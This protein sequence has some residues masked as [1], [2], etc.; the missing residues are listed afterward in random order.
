[1]YFPRIFAEEHTQKRSSS[2][3]EGTFFRIFF[4]GFPKIFVHIQDQNRHF[5]VQGPEVPCLMYSGPLM[6]VGN[7]C[8]KQCPSYH[9]IP[10]NTC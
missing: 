5:L 7:H 1:M 2:Q 8:S 6:A 4:G 10:E 9:L 3:T